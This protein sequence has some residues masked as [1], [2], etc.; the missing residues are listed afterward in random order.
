MNTNSEQFE[1]RWDR[2]KGQLRQQWGDLTDDEL[3]ESKGN[4]EELIGKIPRCH[5]VSNRQCRRLDHLAAVRR[6]NLRADEPG[7]FRNHYE[8]DEP[9]GFEVR[10]RPRHL[11]QFQRAAF[12]FDAGSS[13]QTSVGGSKLGKPESARK[14]LANC[15]TPSGV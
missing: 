2:V 14:L 13:E 9:A 3:E 12:R 7:V 10:Q 4:R 1:G 15:G 6:Q 8:L 11:L 5:P